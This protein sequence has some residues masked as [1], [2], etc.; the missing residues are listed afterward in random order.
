VRLLA[1]LALAALAGCNAA[2][3]TPAPTAS[4][5][6]AAPD[7]AAA[8]L[9]TTQIEPPQAGPFAPRD[10][11]G[12]LDGAY[13]FRLELAEAAQKRDAAALTALA[14][15]GIKL[16]F[17]EGSGPALLRERLAV[18][19]WQLWEALDAIL[20]LGCAV[21]GEGALVMPSYFDQ[22][23]GDRDPYSL[24]VVL[25]SKVPLRAEARP[26]GKVLRELSWDGVELTDF[27][28]EVGPWEAARTADGTKGFVEGAKLRSLLDY[29]LL[30]EK[31][32]QGWKLTAFVAGD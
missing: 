6:E 32:K 1:G 2:P 25:G 30:A 10:T 14:A 24:F 9:L 16:D 20:P 23:I 8:R 28:G 5:S 3:D 12:G 13:Q 29:R 22:D 21:S 27:D 7:S 19:E 26:E 4:A 18:P 11:C 17:G 15:P 31:G